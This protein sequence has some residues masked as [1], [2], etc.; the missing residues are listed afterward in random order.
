MNIAIISPE[1]PTYSNWGGIAT[2]NNSLVELLTD[3]GHHV[4]LLTYGEEHEA[5]EKKLNRKGSIT[6]IYIPRKPRNV[7]FEKLYSSLPVRMF[8]SVLNKKLPYS[9]FSVEWN[10]FVFFTFRRLARSISIDLIHTSSQHLPGFLVNWKISQAPLIFHVQRADFFKRYNYGSLDFK[11]KRF[12]DDLYVKKIAD[13][14]IICSKLEKQAFLKK[15][16]YTKNRLRFIPNFLESVSNYSNS[17]QTDNNLN[18]IVYFGRLEYIKGVDLLLKAFID[19]A[20][21]DKVVK[22]LLIGEDS[23]T[24]EVNKSEASFEDLLNSL[25]LPGDI[26]DRIYLLPRVDDRKFLFEILRALKGIAVFVSRKDAFGFTVIEAMALGFVVI[27]SERVGSSYVIEDGKNG[28]RVTTSKN[29]I[30]NKIT[31]CRKLPDD[32]VRRISNSAYR[33]V[34]EHFT[35][36][37]VKDSYIEL[38][39][40]LGF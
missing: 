37:K 33:T 25:S 17:K 18:N 5:R 21:R 12:F 35:M 22:L 36:D 34:K 14:I 38:Y 24:F 23:L 27:A 19:V 31:L 3:M 2:F 9:F 7:F 29:A 15:Y 20:K 26:R 6:E 1:F 28:F 11:I 10:L 8:R 16:P 40:S 39:R 32:K 30:V 4:Y 13:H